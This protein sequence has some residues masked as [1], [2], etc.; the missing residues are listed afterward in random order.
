M[1]EAPAAP[2]A[3]PELPAPIPP[4]GATRKPVRGWLWFLLI[5]ALAGGGYYYYERYKEQKAGADAA[6]KAAEET[7]G[8]GKGLGG[9]TPVVAVPARTGNINVHIYALGT[10]TPLRTVTVRSRVDGQLMRVHFR[11]GE[12]VQQG[13]LLAEID[14]RPF[15]VL[16]KQAEGQLAR[17]QALLTNARLDLERYRTLLA[18]DS[19][20]K[21]QVDS[22]EAL[23]QQYEGI[24]K[25][26]QSQVENARLQLTYAR[27]TAPI[28]G[29]VGLRLVDPGNIVRSGDATG[30]VVIAQIAPIGVVFTVPQD[31]LPELMKRVQSGDTLRAEAWDREQKN[32]LAMGRL[33]AVDNLVDVSTGS[34]KL[35]ATFRNEDD[36]LFPNQFVNVRLRLETLEDQTVILHTAV[37][38]GGRGLFV[39]VVR[40]DNTV[41]ARPITLGPVDGPRVAVLKGVQPGDRVVIDG[42]DRLRE[43]ARVQVTKRPEFK[44]TIDGTSGARKKGKGKGGAAADKGAAPGAEPAGAPAD[45]AE[46]GAPPDGERKG[47]R[48]SQD[49]EE[50]KAGT[51]DPGA[52]ADSGDPPKKKGRRKPPPDAQDESVAPAPGRGADTPT[53]ADSGDP[54]KKKGRR[55]PPPDAQDADVGGRPPADPRGSAAP[56]EGEDVRRQNVPRKP[57]TAGREPDAPRESSPGPAI[58]PP[59]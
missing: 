59:Q 23:V 21:Q 38:R 50:G 22:Q 34:V 57:P 13:Q 10:V 47:R 20:A 28:S 58:P 15:N 6:K 49:A 43:G 18:Q 40:D 24:V 27:V 53:A 39:Y 42:I 9:P 4:A 35:K 19:I 5:V 37:Q 51:R 14:P 16:L 25:S 26:D 1:S 52:A 48:R 56:G 55:K 3:P 44:P 17:D 30:I 2:N 7:K 41:T 54:P 29:R 45:G 11:E 12:T 36:E 46:K 33:L 32:R 31:N 8:K